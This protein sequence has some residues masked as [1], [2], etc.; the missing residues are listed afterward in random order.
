ML[1]AKSLGQSRLTS[2]YNIKVYK[3]S[4][5]VRAMDSAGTTHTLHCICSSSMWFPLN[6]FS[7]YN[8]YAIPI[9]P[10]LATCYPPFQPSEHSVM[11]TIIYVLHKQLPLIHPFTSLR[12]NRALYLFLNTSLAW[13]CLTVRYMT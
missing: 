6:I 9:F 13:C 12:P 4:Q 5:T 1:N 10:V 3:R 2:L 7:K 8:F 11:Y